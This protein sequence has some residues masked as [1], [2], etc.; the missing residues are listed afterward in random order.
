[1]RHSATLPNCMALSLPEFV[2]PVDCRCPDGGL[3]LQ[4]GGK[5]GL[6][7]LRKQTKSVGLPADS[8]PGG[9]ALA[10]CPSRMQLPVRS[11]TDMASGRSGNV[12]MHLEG[13]PSDQLPEVLDTGTTPIR[14]VFLSLSAREP[15]GRDAE[16]I[17]WHTL[18]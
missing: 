17:E 3:E 6:P 9:S 2:Q 10:T 18:D 5:S 8:T 12:N 11:M 7:R 1:L 4:P 16:Y 13:T 15:D 14:H